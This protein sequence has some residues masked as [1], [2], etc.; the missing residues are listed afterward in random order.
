M[1]ESYVDLSYRGL[2]L[3]KRIKLTQ[4]RPA[5]AY[6]ELPMPMPVGTLIGIATDEGVELEAV[7]AEIHEQVAGSER[8]PGMLVRP[9]LDVKAA[10]QWWKARASGVEPKADKAPPPPGD[11]GKV[12]VKSP[13]MTGQT[14]IP[15]VMDDGRNTAVMDA[16]VDAGSSN[17]TLIADLPHDT[18]PAL[19]VVT[20][21]IADDGNRTTAMDA[22]DLAALGLTSPSGQMPAVKPEDYVDDEAGNGGGDKPD[23]TGKTKKKRKRR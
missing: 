4:I 12:T 9:T 8:P 21:P 1:S 20:Q 3:G 16:I 7:V 14:A 15:E 23:A 13:R 18:N 11:D 17:D 2:A 6:L 22:V 10:E 5:S 19:P